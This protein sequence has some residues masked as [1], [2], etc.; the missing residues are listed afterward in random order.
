MRGGLPTERLRELQVAVMLLTRVPAGTLTGTAP[1]IA[2]SSWAW[3]L[4]GAGIGI[5][6]TAVF[7]TANWALPGTM[8]PALL[9]VGA[10]ALI[11]GGM[12]E[13]GLADVADGFGGGQDR[14]RKLEIM[15]DSRIGSYGVIALAL[16]LALR[17][18]GL[19]AVPSQAV[20]AI[21]G[22]FAASRATMAVATARMPAARGDGLGQAA[23]P[24]AGNAHWV[25][26]LLA[27]GFLLPIGG[28]AAL[29]CIA[30]MAL[31]AAVFAALAN[32]QIG[33]QTGDVLGAMQQITEITGWLILAAVFSR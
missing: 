12:H 25:A 8:L 14:A 33:G 29:M 22:L 24:D 30:G 17:V 32:R 20:F 10:C 15:R 16:G 27:A 3:P 21:I 2:A 26:A 31:S 4:V 19:S 28:G 23:R 6:V 5:V 18:A 7:V 13:D 1:S 9:A 11:T